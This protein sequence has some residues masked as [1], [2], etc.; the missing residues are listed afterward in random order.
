MKRQILAVAAA[1]LRQRLRSRR[2][3]VVLA[4]VA[5]FGF[6]LT[7][8]T[9][10]LLYQDTVDD[11]TVDYRGE[12]TAAYVGLTT[13]VTGALLLLLGGYY[14]LSGSLA[15]ARETG[16]NE[17]VASSYV[18]DRAYLLGT[19]LSHVG[20][21]AIILAT[22]GGAAMVNH[23]VHGTG[24]TNPLWILGA[25]FLIGFPVGC[26]VAGIT[27][28]FQSTVRLRGTAGNVG[29]F[30]GAL[31]A[32]TATVTPAIGLDPTAEA[33]L[34][35][36][37]IDIVGLYSAGEMTIDAV[38][39]VAPEYD[40]PPLANYG[41][42]TGEQVVTYQW[43]GG[44]WPVWFLGNRF[45]LMLSGV[46]LVA[47]GAILYDRFEDTADGGGTG[48]F[49]AVIDR[50]RNCI[51]S[52]RVGSS[53]T[54]VDETALSPITDRS[55]SNF[56]RLLIQELRLLI[57]GHQWWWYVGTVLIIG[58]GLTG[59]APSEVIVPIAAIWPLFLWSAMGSRTVRHR[60]MPFIISS[61]QP[62]RQL[63]AE[64]IA[65]GILTLV[66]LGPALWPVLAADP[67]ATIVVAGAV[68]FV[69]S[70]AQAMGLWSRTRRL[71]EITYLVLW[72]VG[73]LNGVVILDFAGATTETVDTTV[74][75]IF[76][77]VG[78][79]ALIAS[80]VHRYQQA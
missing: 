21:V 9:F 38:L 28:V 3:L 42:G 19:W 58:I 77:A 75:L 50:L 30:F 64:W 8:G 6:Q 37:A 12:P 52:R 40:G 35:A 15:R 1:D 49:T 7:I 62:Y 60:M 17:L 2:L 54:E 39:A 66:V 71:F 36:Q 4:F 25:V 72:Y 13:G 5:Y 24:T 73:P 43:D 27:L 78:F 33:P 68:L 76:I 29:Y 46:A 41:T 70:L 45:G 53:G 32:L 56:G 67:V 34:W 59:T 63:F 22:L 14:I 31:T 10:E 20:L 26:L 55:S 16:V 57:R 69:P 44:S 47:F 61:N 65:G 18:T 48:R 74:P 79:V 11:Q 23:T 80:L 51:P